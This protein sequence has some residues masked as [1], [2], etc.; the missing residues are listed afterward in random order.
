MFGVAEA[1]Q[2]SPADLLATLTE[3]TVASI[4][5]SYRTSCPGCLS[6][7][8]VAVAV[9]ILKRRFQIYLEPVP[10]LTTD[11]VGLNADLKAIAFAILAT[12]GS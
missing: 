7:C 6:K 10:V 12:G 8:C 4:V 2:L 11:E 1:H 9:G 5:H 3:L